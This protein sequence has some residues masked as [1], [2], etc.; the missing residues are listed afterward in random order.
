MTYELKPTKTMYEKLERLQNRYLHT[1][2]S[3]N[4]TDNR[5]LARQRHHRKSC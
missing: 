3:L 1:I 5:A 2:L 4:A